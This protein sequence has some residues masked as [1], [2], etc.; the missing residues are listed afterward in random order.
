MM[1]QQ[2]CRCVCTPTPSP[3]FMKQSFT[4]PTPTDKSSRASGWALSDSTVGGSQ[5]HPFPPQLRGPA[6]TFV[7]LPCERSH[8]GGCGAADQ[9]GRHAHALQLVGP[10]LLHCRCHGNYARL[11]HR[12]PPSTSTNH[13]YRRKIAATTSFTHLYLESKLTHHELTTALQLRALLP[14]PPQ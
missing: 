8:I 9:A 6:R 3:W 5:R 7:R 12:L 13:L 4:L 14:S 10:R 2:N 1:L 11:F